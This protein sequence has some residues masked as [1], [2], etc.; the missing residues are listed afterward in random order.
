MY[1][2]VLVCTWYIPGMYL[3]IDTFHTYLGLFGDHIVS[4]GLYRYRPLAVLYRYRQGGWQAS[5]GRPDRDNRG[6]FR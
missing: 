6:D 1:W 4:A 3:Y 2:Y 5:L